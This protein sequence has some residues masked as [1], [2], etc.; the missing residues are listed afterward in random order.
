MSK[1]IVN[2]YKE[3][4]TQV[5]QKFALENNIKIIDENSPG[6][7]LE[8][9]KSL[10]MRMGIDFI[11]VEKQAS[12][13]LFKKSG[14]IECRLFAD[15]NI[16]AFA[17]TINNQQYI[18]IYVGLIHAIRDAFFTLFA[19]KQFF[20]KIGESSQETLEIGQFGLILKANRNYG[21]FLKYLPNCQIRRRCADYMSRLAMIF[22]FSHEMTHL[23]K[24]HTTYDLIKYGFKAYYE[25]QDE[26]FTPEQLF[27]RR[28]LEL[29]ADIGGAKF[30]LKFLE[31]TNN[32]G[33]Y[34]EFH[35]IHIYEIWLNVIQ[36]LFKVLNPWSEFKENLNASHPNDLMRLINI[37]KTSLDEA[38]SLKLIKNED[39]GFELFDKSIE[40]QK[41]FFEIGLVPINLSSDQ[42]NLELLN[43]Y[44]VRRAE[45]YKSDLNNLIIKRQKIIDQ[46]Y[47][48]LLNMKN[49]V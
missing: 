23:A 38:L 2:P 41:V 16:N 43:K 17:S 10:L 18:G 36:V 44:K 15:N 27:D 21:T 4:M 26:E 31:G 9:A 42:E 3:E 13:D 8:I 1:I 14:W 49:A 46:D 33:D 19:S 37:F 5:F 7:N 11:D 45:I 29:D 28:A 32:F 30:S 35:D 39:E 47:N 25:F 6:N 12:L 22:I 20:K 24:C 48:Y 40:L 34:S